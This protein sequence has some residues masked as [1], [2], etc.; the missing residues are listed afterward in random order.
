MPVTEKAR[1]NCDSRKLISV[2]AKEASQ[3]L[4]V[5]KKIDPEAHIVKKEVGT[6]TC[7]V[8]EDSPWYPRSKK[9]VASRGELAYQE[10]ERRADASQAWKYD[11]TRSDEYFSYR[12][13]APRNG[14][15]RCETAGRSIEAA[16]IG[17]YLLIDQKY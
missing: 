11:R 5:V 4:A 6:D 9:Y 15:R 3:I 10:G 16:C 8:P 2:A 14:T 7:I 13:W 12:E 1:R 17:I